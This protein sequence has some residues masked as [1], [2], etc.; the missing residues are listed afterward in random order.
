MFNKLKNKLKGIK[1]C[2]DE[3]VEYAKEYLADK[4][5]RVATGVIVTG[6]GI[7]T[8]VLG[9]ALIITGYISMPEQS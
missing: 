7:G 8:A 1:K 6:L 9:V 5:N 2:M 4:G 3:R